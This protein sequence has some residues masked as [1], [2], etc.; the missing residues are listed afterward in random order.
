MPYVAWVDESD[1]ADTEI[2][3]RR[4]TGSSWKNLG[5]SASGGGISNNAAPSQDP[6]IAVD[7][8]GRAIVA[9]GDLRSSGASEIY[10]KR[11]NGSGWED[12]GGSSGGSGVS[13]T[14]SF[15]YEPSAAVG[16][17]GTP[18]VAWSAVAANV[19]IY[20]RRYMTD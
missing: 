9:W 5:G 16:P 4:W 20:V 18:Y 2:Y 1:D 7:R 13:N 14:G 12:V 19:E 17:D 11:W 3:A 10:L 8:F 6:S 15:S